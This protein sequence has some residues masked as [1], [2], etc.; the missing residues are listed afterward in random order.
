[1]DLDSSLLL[2][3]YRAA[4]SMPVAEFPEFA[5]GLWRSHIG[6]DSARLLSV[7][8]DG[9]A[10][11]IRSCVAHN[12]AGDHLLDWAAINRKDLVLTAIREQPSRP[13]SFHVATLFAAREYAI[14]RDYAA[15]Y[16]H[17]NGLC[18][19]LPDAESGYT[20]G[21]SLYRARDDNHFGRPEQLLLRNLMPHLIEALKLNRALAAA[22]PEAVHPTLLIARL[23]GA[24][25]YCTE[26][27]SELLAMEW[28]DWHGARL[29]ARLQHELARPG[30]TGYQG[31]YLSVSAERVGQ[32]LFLR[33]R[34]QS[35][36]AQLSPREREVARMYGCGASTKVIAAELGLAPTTVRNFV[37]RIYQKLSVG[38]KAALA[39]ML[40]GAR[41]YAA[42]GTRAADDGRRPW[43]ATTDSSASPPSSNSQLEDSGTA[44]TAK[45]AP[46]S[47]E[48]WKLDKA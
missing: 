33:L 8:F 20:D 5:L 1:M 13:V 41:Y 44:A 6:F 22:T 9:G 21:L 25:H 2:A 34:P 48:K 15:R 31:A 3:M 30:A 46:L 4:R 12:V 24:V 38:D 17:A 27:A 23:D 29:P 45:L 7:Q 47:V 10:T 40:A 18:V 16:D 37:Q 36:L 35:P 11:L 42:S 28:R 19:A 32:L 39:S 43:R 26:A 14:V